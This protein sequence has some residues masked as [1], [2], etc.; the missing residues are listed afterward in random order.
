M[1]GNYCNGEEKARIITWR[2]ENIKIKTMCDRTGRA[3]STIMKVLAASSE[4]EP[5]FIHGGGMQKK[6]SNAADGLLKM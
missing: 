4:L 1:P 5:N 2:Q 3:K 6:T